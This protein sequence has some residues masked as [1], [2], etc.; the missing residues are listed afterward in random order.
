KVAR[1]D[2]PLV[3]GA[4]LP[5]GDAAEVERERHVDRALL[6]RVVPKLPIFGVPPG[7]LRATDVFLP[8][9]V[10]I[11]PDAIADLAAGGEATL[12]L[13]GDQP[14]DGRVVHHGVA[15]LRAVDV[16]VVVEEE[17]NFPLGA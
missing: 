3:G 5:L 6:D 10:P 2:Q 7:P 12:T 13:I 11:K 17:A 9:G 1:G 16:P 8:A 15:N 14:F 4:L